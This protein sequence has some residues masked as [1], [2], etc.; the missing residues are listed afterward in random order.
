ML[1]NYSIFTCRTFVIKRQKHING[2]NENGRQKMATNKTWN[3]TEIPFFAVVFF[4]VVRFLI[5][6]VT[7]RLSF[8]LHF[9]SRIAYRTVLRWCSVINLQHIMDF[10]ILVVELKVILSAAEDYW[11][12]INIHLHY[13]RVS[14]HFLHR[15]TLQCCWKCLSTSPAIQKQTSQQ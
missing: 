10:I 15:H 4:F 6:N 2:N 11:E 5:N 8:S 3:H 12:V 1:H 7:R 9:F 13:H 14:P